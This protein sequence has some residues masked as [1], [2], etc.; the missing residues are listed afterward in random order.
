MKNKITNSRKPALQSSVQA[1]VDKASKSTTQDHA[2]LI[3]RRSLLKG[4]GAA[5][6]VIT[7]HSGAAM[8]AQSNIGHCIGPNDVEPTGCVKKADR[9]LRVEVDKQNGTVDSDIYGTLEHSLYS[10]EPSEKNDNLCLINVTSDGDILPVDS[11]DP[12]LV[13]TTSCWTSFV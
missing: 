2:T 12:M 4:L 1:P 13:A 9:W 3:R 8:A 6:L 10:D 5:P 11:H 7:L